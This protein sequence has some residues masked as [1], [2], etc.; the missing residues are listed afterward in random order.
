[1]LCLRSTVPQAAA[2]TPPHALTALCPALGTPLSTRSRTWSTPP[3]LW[4]GQGP[5]SLA[6]ALQ[7]SPRLWTVHG[8]SPCSC[9]A[10]SLYAIGSASCLSVDLPGPQC[11]SAG[12]ATKMLQGLKPC[13]ATSGRRLAGQL[14]PSRA[15]SRNVN[16]VPTRCALRYLLMNTAMV[17]AACRYLSVDPSHRGAVT[18]YSIA[19]LT[20]CLALCADDTCA[21]A[22]YDYA[23]QSCTTV[24]VLAS[25]VGT[26][27]G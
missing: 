1:M 18:N 24:S 11:I 2:R 17:V 9:L 14:K 4:P 22:T 6:T 21:F 20:D 5:T 16:Q 23:N 19:N 27:L 26:G 3:K 8:E 10:C 25:L 13:F 7:S 15:L 12:G